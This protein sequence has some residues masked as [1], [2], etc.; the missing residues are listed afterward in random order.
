MAES[1]SDTGEDE[2]RP[3]VRCEAREAVYWITI[4]RPERR[5]AFNDEVA[6]RIAAGPRS[7]G[8]LE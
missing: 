3:A 4:D 1:R 2:T 6:A 8:V 7:P 5:N